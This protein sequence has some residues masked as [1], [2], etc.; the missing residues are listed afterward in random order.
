MLP[1]L[2]HKTL[3]IPRQSTPAGAPGQRGT[4]LYSSGVIPAGLRPEAADLPPRLVSQSA[5]SHARHRA[6]GGA[7]KRP[8]PT[9]VRLTYWCSFVD[10][11]A[12]TGLRSRT[13]EMLK[14]AAERLSVSLQP[15][16]EARE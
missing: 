3:T 7:G 16:S 1:R 9:F 15:E 6:G 2:H 12:E 10:R 5:S 8:G 4:Q 14:V 13:A 11:S